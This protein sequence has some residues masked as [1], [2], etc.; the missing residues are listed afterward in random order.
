MGTAQ[1]GGNG[2]IGLVVLGDMGR[3]PRMQ[4][5]AVEFLKRGFDVHMIGYC[6]S[7]FPTALSQNRGFHPHALQPFPSYLDQRLPYVV[8]APLKAMWLF[9]VLLVALFTNLVL[10]Y[11]PRLVLIQNP[12]AIPSIFC[13]VLICRLFLW[14]T[15]VWIDWHNLAHTL[16][17]PKLA[18]LAMI[19]EYWCAGF[20]DL[21]ICVTNALQTHVEHALPLYSVSRSVCCFSMFKKHKQ[22]VSAK[23][24]EVVVL[25]DRP[26]DRFQPVVLSA[27]RIS[28]R[29]RIVPSVEWKTSTVLVVSG[30]SWT[31]DED[32][33]ILLN[34]ISGLDLM[35]QEW[36]TSAA[37]TSSRLHFVFA[38]TGKGPLK[39]FYQEKIRQMDFQFCTVLTLWLAADDYPSLLASADLGVCLHTS[40]SGLDL[41]M[42]VLD[43]FGSGIPA[44]AVHYDCLSE[45]VKHGHNGLEFSDW[46]DLRDRLFS[47]FVD[48]PAALQE[49]TAYVRNVETQSRFPQEWETSVGALLPNV[50]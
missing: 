13:T 9:V 12:P 30:T 29:R 23:K 26:A 22:P 7:D 32:F 43:M 44:L 39:S 14:K 47:L 17:P 19:T 21:H 46:A 3:S 18:A 38:I 16:T 45:L 50:S 27:E 48:N 36:S 35:L 2:S 37:M 1:K 25:H 11:R 34:A 28:I 20:A 49:M 10:K 41:P 40:S 6:G 15:K 31:P 33:S 24:L 5:H 4:Y 42:K 8:K